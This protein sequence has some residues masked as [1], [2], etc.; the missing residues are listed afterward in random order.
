MPTRKFSFPSQ[1]TE[2]YS[3]IH[4]Q[5]ERPSLFTFLSP[6]A[7]TARAYNRSNLLVYSIALP[8]SMAACAVKDIICNYPRSQMSR[9]GFHNTDKGLKPSVFAVAHNLLYSAHQDVRTRSST[10]PPKESRMPEPAGLRQRR[11]SCI[12]SSPNRH[13]NLGKTENDER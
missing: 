7:N 11:R 9:F 1:S 5:C 4:D 10:P 8:D 3:L 12:G 6:A 2:N 13:N